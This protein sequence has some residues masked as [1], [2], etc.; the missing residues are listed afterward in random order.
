[1]PSRRIEEAVAT[2]DVRARFEMTG[3]VVRSGSADEMRRVLATDVVKWAK[4]VK[5]RMC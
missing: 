2:P 4:L 5:E 3:A 1:M